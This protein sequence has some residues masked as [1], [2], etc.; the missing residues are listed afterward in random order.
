MYIVGT[1]CALVIVVVAGTLTP[2]DNTTSTPTMITLS[3]IYSKIQ[4]LSYSATSSDHSVSTTSSPVGT[5]NTLSQVYTLLDDLDYTAE[6]IATGTSIMGVVGNITIPA[7]ADVRLSTAYGPNNTLTGELVIPTDPNAETG[8]LVISGA[9]GDYASCNGAYHLA[10]G[11]YGG[12]A[13]FTNGVAEEGCWIY[14][15]GGGTAM[16]WAINTNEAWA[17]GY[18]GHYLRGAYQNYNDPTYAL[19]ESSI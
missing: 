19:V 8:S 13:H 10:V 14:Y 17:G 11:T 9:A 4:D 3:D 5:F 18:Y 15:I 16:N 2:G 1:L 12:H 7:E 6:D